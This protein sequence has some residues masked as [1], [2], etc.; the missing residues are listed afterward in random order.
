MFHL[1]I[2]CLKRLTNRQNIKEKWNK[3]G[4]LIHSFSEEVMHWDANMYKLGSNFE[5]LSYAVIEAY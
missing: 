1:E 3:D 5:F 4:K 2:P